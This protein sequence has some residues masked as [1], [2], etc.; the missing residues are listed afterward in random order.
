MSKI[1][2]AINSWQTLLTAWFKLNKI[3]DFTKSL[4]TYNGTAIAIGLLE[5]DSQ[6]IDIF[7]KASTVMLRIQLG[8]FFAWFLLS[9]NIQGH[10][11]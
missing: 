5:H 3:D 8:Q 7:E 6:I 11:I 2:S 9:E 10:D 1:K 4:N